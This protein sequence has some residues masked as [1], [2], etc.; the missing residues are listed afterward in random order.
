MKEIIDLIKILFTRKRDFKKLIA[1][2]GGPEGLAQQLE[3][4]GWYKIVAN[5]SKTVYKKDGITI[6]FEDTKNENP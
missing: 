2:S 4:G 5:G 3:K 1:L 6:S